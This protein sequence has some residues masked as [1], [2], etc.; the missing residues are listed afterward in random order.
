MESVVPVAAAAAVAEPRRSDLEN[1]APIS[2]AFTVM[3]G[4]VLPLDD[5]DDDDDDDG[6]GG[7]SRGMRRAA[8]MRTWG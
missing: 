4:F 6:G 1:T 7:G 3:P 8:T 2:V 5:D